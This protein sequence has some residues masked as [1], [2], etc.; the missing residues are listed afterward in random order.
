MLICITTYGRTPALWRHDHGVL[1]IFLAKWFYWYMNNTPVGDSIYDNI[2]YPKISR[3]ARG[4]K[5]LWYR[6]ISFKFGFLLGS[7]ATAAELQSYWPILKNNFET[8]RFYQ[9]SNLIEK[10]YD[11]E[12]SRSPRQ[13]MI[14]QINILNCPGISRLQVVY[15]SGG[16]SCEQST[17]Y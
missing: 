6:L 2:P 16:K 1:L 3:D 11:F 17:W 4:P 10:F 13:N 5:T 8:S 12:I 15:R 14:Y 9:L 7:C